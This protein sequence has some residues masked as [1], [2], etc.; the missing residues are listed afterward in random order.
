[1]IRKLS[2]I[3]LALCFSQALASGQTPQEK[4]LSFTYEKL[5]WTLT[6]PADDFEL[7]QERLKQDGNGAYF[8]IVDRKQKINLSMFI[9]P[10]TKCRD[11]KSCSEMVWKAGNPKW[12]NPQNVSHSQIGDVSIFEF[13]IP[14]YQGMP[15][16][17]QNM[18]AQFVVNGFWVDMH[19]SK[20]LYEPSERRLFERIIKAVKFEPKPKQNEN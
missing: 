2:S 12:N 4:R 7:A 1:M 19:I 20:V 17:Q 5:P 10:A 9:E 8:Y 16:R 18:Y 13:L 14:S 11:S 15:I 6:L 3:A